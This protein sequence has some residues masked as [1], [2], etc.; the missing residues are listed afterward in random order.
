MIL[1]C[2]RHAES[3]Y[4][5]EGRIQGQA[6]PPLS[7]TGLAQAAA[8]AAGLKQFPRVDAL[9]CSPLQ[10]AMQTAAPISDALGLEIRTI[11]QLK[12]LNAG[13]FQGKRWDEIEEL[14]PEEARTWKSLEP[15]FVI[16]G[17]ESRRQLMHRGRAALE[18]IR[19]SG[20]ERV[21]VVSHGGL[22]TAA[23]K[24]LLNV[25]ADTNPFM[26][27]NASVSQLVWPSADSTA[28]KLLTLN[29]T[30]FLRDAGCAT[31][32]GDL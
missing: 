15:D 32:S 21:I 13:I 27:M 12:E 23:L 22:L 26:L 9:F 17:G 4:N 14:Y 19:R 2:V 31:R 8:L 28:V 24:A 25:P 20:F 11:D 5:G 10:R 6:D 18:S 29:E 7:Q 3:V 16:P 30:W 1:Y